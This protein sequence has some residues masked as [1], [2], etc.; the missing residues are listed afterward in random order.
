LSLS[1][2]SLGVLYCSASNFDHAREAFQKALDC[3]ERQLR[4]YLNLGQL[5]D[6]HFAEQAATDEERQE[7]KEKAILHYKRVLKLDSSNEQA[8]GRLM[9]LGAPEARKAE[10]L[11]LATTESMPFDEDEVSFFC[12]CQ[13]KPH[14]ISR[15]TSDAETFPEDPFRRVL[16]QAHEQPAE[17]QVH[18]E[19]AGLTSP[20]EWPQDP[21]PI[22]TPVATASIEPS[23]PEL[24]TVQEQSSRRSPSAMSRSSS[25]FKRLED[26]ISTLLKRQTGRLRVKYLKRDV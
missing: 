14:L 4:A 7:C 12:S 25:D 22:S 17:A 10:T 9:A 23:G 19:E 16:P 2:C 21:P 11:S 26:M 15:Q 13:A 1:Q 20:T 6:F 18:V 3:D 8:R 24:P 5:Y